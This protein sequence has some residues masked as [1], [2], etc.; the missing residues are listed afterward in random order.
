MAIFVL[1][2]GLCSCSCSPA[3]DIDYADAE[4]F[5]IML[6]EGEDMKD[7]VV[8]FTVA[9]YKPDS[10][11]GCNIW[12]GEHLNF[13]SLFKSLV[14]LLELIPLKCLFIMLNTLSTLFHRL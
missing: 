1:M 8:Q 14:L 4:S 11:Y 13:V 12:A 7:K 5:E 3:V 6:N 10:L 9:D 2:L